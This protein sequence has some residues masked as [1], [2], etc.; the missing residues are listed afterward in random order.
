MDGPGD[1][2]TKWISELNQR[3]TN[4]TWY[5]LHVESKKKKN[6][7]NKPIYKTETVSQTYKTNLRLPKGAKGEG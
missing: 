6:Y 2:H 4:I 3:K 7:T 1:Y 5:P